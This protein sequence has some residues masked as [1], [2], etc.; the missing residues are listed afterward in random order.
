MY[1]VAIAAGMDGL[2]DRTMSHEKQMYACN[3]VGGI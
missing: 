1:Q 3:A 2:Y